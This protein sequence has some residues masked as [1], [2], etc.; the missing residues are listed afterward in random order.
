MAR[1]ECRTSLLLVARLRKAGGLALLLLLAASPAKVAAQN[2][3]TF[4][5]LLGQGISVEEAGSA[6][7]LTSA[8]VQACLA[9]TSL[10]KGG[11]APY[12]AA[13]PAPHGA[14][15]PAPHGAAGPA[16][17]GAAGPA[18]HGAAGPPPHGAAGPAPHGAAG[19]SY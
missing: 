2:C 7:G 1:D 4:R 15:G 5:V 19:P 17:H 9:R 11:P 10:P 3:S 12:G 18:P 14:P 16:P 8:E 6:L 13:G